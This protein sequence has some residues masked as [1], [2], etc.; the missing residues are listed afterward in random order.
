M[1][2]TKEEHKIF[3]QH[4][5]NQ[6][7]WERLYEDTALVSKKKFTKDD[8]LGHIKK[9]ILE[10][11]IYY[12]TS[13]IEGRVEK[14]T[15]TLAVKVGTINNYYYIISQPMK[16]PNGEYL[17]WFM[18]E[19]DFLKYIDLHKKANRYCIVVN[20]KNCLRNHKIN[21]ICQTLTQIT[22]SIPE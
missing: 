12:D 2:P 13:C 6:L 20:I 15:S 22:N 1:I 5:Y 9:L 16:R 21:K 4:L 3:S 19:E 8:I 11:P 10:Y 18:T 17:S 14:S 7:D